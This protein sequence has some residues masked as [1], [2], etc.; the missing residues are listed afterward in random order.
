MAMISGVAIM[1]LYWHSHRNNGLGPAISAIF[2]WKFAPTLIA[3]IYTQLTTILF[4]DVKRTEPFA[5]LARPAGRVPIAARTILETP[6]A[7]WV[8]LVLGFQKKHNGGQRS[9]VLIMACLI[10]VLAFLAISPLSSALLGVDDMRISRPVEMT[11]MMPK[12][13]SVLK[14]F[15]DRDM[16][17]RTTAALLQN[18]T[19]S[20]WI[21]N[22]YSVL[23]FWPVETTGS[24]WNAQALQSPRTWRAETAVFRAGFT[25]AKMELA[26]TALFNKTLPDD[27]TPTLMASVRLDSSDG[28]QY[29]MTS[30]A[31]DAYDPGW[32][33][34]WADAAHIAD[35]DN[36]RGELLDEEIPAT[37]NDKCHGDEAII[38]GNTWLDY[39]PMKSNKTKFLSNMTTWGY[40][41]SSTLS[42]AT[43]PVIASVSDTSFDINFDEADFTRLQKPVPESLLKHSDLLPI[44]TNPEWYQY[45]PTPNLITK[46]SEFSGI[47]ALLATHYGLNADLMAKAADLPEQAARIRRRHFGELLRSSLDAVGASQMDRIWA[48][49]AVVERRVNVSMEAAALLAGL[50]FVSSLMLLYVTWF[51]RITQR[52]LNLV[53][54]PAT[55][56]GTTSLIARSADVL[57]SLR[58]LDQASTQELRDGLRNHVYYTSAGH[59]HQEFAHGQPAVAGKYPSSAAVFMLTIWS[60]PAPKTAVKTAQKSPFFLKL[61]ALLGLLIY[62]ILLLAALVVVHQF[63]TKSSLRQA[64]FTYRVNS[65]TFGSFAPFSIIPTTLGIAVGLWWNGQIVPISPAL[66]DHVEG[67]CQNGTRSRSFVS[68]YALVVGIFP[69]CKK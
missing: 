61:W 68:V 3:V 38:V 53:H 29:N 50:F 12:Q 1:L 55:V 9:W 67:T 36:Y 65:K 51:S 23:P 45:V 59:L 33:F 69:S 17:F 7:W 8:T 60:D 4:D 66:C 52:P 58:G 39:D 46:S 18:V 20:P 49:E 22:D 10:N 34:S 6:K 5:R 41:C 31:D 54:D 57:T 37:S 24:P 42:M 47:S 26:K 21:S 15:E 19:T 25:C 35:Q 44:F 30:S 43:L 56:L 62:L 2:G 11:R 28:C 16:F 14:P 63:A 48:E 64:L 13:D 27:K 40:M 32:F